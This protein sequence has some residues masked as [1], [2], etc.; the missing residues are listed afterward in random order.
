M[1]KRT[2]FCL[3]KKFTLNSLGLS[4]FLAVLNFGSLAQANDW[5]DFDFFSDDTTLSCEAALAE[6]TEALSS[7][8]WNC[9]EENDKELTKISGASAAAP[10]LGAASSL[11]DACSRA[12]DIATAANGAFSAFQA[13]CSYRVASCSS[14]CNKAVGACKNQ[15]SKSIAQENANSC[16]DW[17]QVATAA[18]TNAASALTARASAMGCSDQAGMSTAEYCKQNPTATGCAKVDC[19]K[20]EFKNTKDCICQANPMD[21]QCG[22]GQNPNAKIPDYKVNPSL[23]NDLDDEGSGRVPSTS[24][25]SSLVGDGLTEDPN[26]AGANKGGAARGIGKGN[27]SGATSGGDGGGGGG[28]RGREA[29]GDDDDG[30]NLMGG[31]SGGAGYYNPGGRTGEEKNDPRYGRPQGPIPQG[32]D[33]KK[34]L[35]GQP[36]DQKRQVA[37]ATGPDGI[38]CAMCSSLFEKVNKRYQVLSTSMQP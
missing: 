32:I 11:F 2:L 8:Q 6:C 24:D 18:A 1:L 33:L 3:F 38:T 36:M 23:G 34:F 13:N 27:G 17:G 5:F 10:L 4:V 12:Q 20:A 26:K 25:F 19:S 16:K 37:G 28:G 22:S 29:Y 9:N 7:A 14:S 35:P 30:I 21:P 15:D 31:R